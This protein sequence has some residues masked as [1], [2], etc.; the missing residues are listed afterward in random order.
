MSLRRLVMFGVFVVAVCG[1]ATAPPARARAAADSLPARLSDQDFWKLVQDLSEPD[2]SFRSDNLVSNE[3]QFQAVIPDLIRIARP[4]RVYLGVGPEQNFTYMAAIKPSMAFIID[5]RRGN[6]DLHLLYKAL[7]ELSADRAEFVSL[8]FSRPRPR[9]LTPKSSAAEMFQAYTSVFTNWRLY[10]ETMSSIRNQL[11]TKHRFALSEE[12]LNGLEYVFRAFFMFGP[13]LQYSPVGLAGG[14]VQPTYAALMAATDDRGEARGFLSSEEAF[15][16]V[17]NLESRNLIVPVVGNF[18]GPKAIRA[19]GAYLK[20]KGA[21]VS[22]FYLSNV[23]EYLRRDGI[24]QDFCDNVATLP[25]D[26]ASTFIRSVR[27]VTDDPV[28]GLRSE[29]GEMTAIGNCR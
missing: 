10:I 6:L 18:A 20:Q 29:L 27:T 9:G 11:L 23:E 14:T 19:V 21:T 12:D 7:F 3:R 16:F 4:G 26:E 8:L 28:G 25:S 24:W 15:A 22:T 17:K 13:Q 1:M 5:V 2:G